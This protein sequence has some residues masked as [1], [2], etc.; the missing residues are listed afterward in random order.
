MS[1]FEKIKAKNIASH[2]QCKDCMSYIENYKDDY[3]IRHFNYGKV[4]YRPACSFGNSYGF[5]SQN[6]ARLCR[7]YKKNNTTKQTNFEKSIRKR[8]Y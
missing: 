3:T 6:P 8:G 5:V 7:H 4:S 2:K 1:N